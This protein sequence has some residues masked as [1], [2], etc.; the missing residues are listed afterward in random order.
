MITI[1]FSDSAITFKGLDEHIEY[2]VVEVK[3][4]KKGKDV[5]DASKIID[6]YDD[7]F[8]G[9]AKYYIDS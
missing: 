4:S 8:S 2:I 6:Y 1:T 3:S 5:Y 9:K 7:Y